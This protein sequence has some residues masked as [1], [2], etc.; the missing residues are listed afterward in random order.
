M[1]EGMRVVDWSIGKIVEVADRVGVTVFV[2]KLVFTGGENI[3]EVV[4][5][6]VEFVRIGVGVIVELEMVSVRE[7]VG[8]EVFTNLVVVVVGASEDEELIAVLF[9]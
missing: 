4:A 1:T 2:R 9:A 8:V 5:I 7:T 6:R 3:L